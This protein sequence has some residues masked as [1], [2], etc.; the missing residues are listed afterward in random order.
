VVL[1]KVIVHYT[2]FA[3]GGGGRRRGVLL[4]VLK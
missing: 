3:I 2:E 4:Q 1:S